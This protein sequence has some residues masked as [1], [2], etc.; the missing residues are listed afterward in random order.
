MSSKESVTHWLAQLQAG[1]PA[2]AQHLWE[3]YFRRLVQ[4]ARKRLQESPRRTADE[5]DVALSAFGSFCRHAEQG[6][7]PQLGDRDCLWRLLVVIT[8]RKAFHLLRHEASQKQGG[9]RIFRADTAEADEEVFERALSREPS[10]EFAAE[11]AEQCQ[12]LLAVLQD[13]ELQSVAL[14]RMEGYSVKEIATKLGCV[15]RSVK[16]KLQTIRTLWEKETPS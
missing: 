6:Q 2:A 8:A 14:W 7:F 12:Q 10:P 13:R 11:V 16:R 3:R 5:E 4:L 1:N 15:S 9:G